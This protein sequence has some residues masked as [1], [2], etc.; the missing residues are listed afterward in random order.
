[1]GESGPLVSVF[2]QQPITG[3]LLIATNGRLLN[4]EYNRNRALRG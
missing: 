3:N 4:F 2:Y 1:M